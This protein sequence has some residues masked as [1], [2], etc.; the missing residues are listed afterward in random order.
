MTSEQPSVGIYCLK[1]LILKSHH[2]T[3]MK[4]K[5]LWNT[6]M[7]I[8]NYLSMHSIIIIIFF[9]FY[10]TFAYQLYVSLFKKLFD[11]DEHQRLQFPVTLYNKVPLLNVS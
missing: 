4:K 8:L 6:A 7:F 3:K 5:S 9:T 2:E 1:N 10:Y 11:F